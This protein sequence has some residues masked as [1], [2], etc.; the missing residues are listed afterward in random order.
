MK[1][2]EQVNNERRYS[3]KIKEQVS[4]D[5]RYSRRINRVFKG[6][7]IEHVDTRMCNMWKFHFTDGTIVEAETEAIGYGLYGFA[8][9]P[10]TKA[11]A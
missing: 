8:L 6:K 7:T 3:R 2:K 9:V 10:P 11:V 4:D 1:T 5:R